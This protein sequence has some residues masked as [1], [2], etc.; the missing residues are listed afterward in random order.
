MSD[1][2][3][4]SGFKELQAH[5]GQDIAEFLNFGGAPVELLD[6]DVASVQGA[7][8]GVWQIPAIPELRPQAHLLNVQ[9]Q[10]GHKPDLPELEF[11][12]TGILSRKF[13]QR[14]ITVVLYLK[15]E[16]YRGSQSGLHVEAVNGFEIARFWYLPVK[17]WEQDPEVLLSRVGTAPFAVLTARDEAQAD[18]VIDRITQR[19]RGEAEN[20]QARIAAVSYVFTGLNFDVEFAERL[21]R[22]YPAMEESVTYQHIKRLGREEGLETGLQDALLLGFARTRFGEPDQA[23]IDAIRAIHDRDRLLR[24]A[25]RAATAASWAD[26]LQ[27]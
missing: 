13:R 18:A 19:I 21:I 20:V 22:S 27:T 11:Q 3:A 5:H 15:P 9:A 24:M 12:N 1:K 16:A 2:H 17:M 10:A 4:D 7:V 6:S 23:T 25:S 8:D 14:V 26:L